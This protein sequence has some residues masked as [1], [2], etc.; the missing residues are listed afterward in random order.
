MHC[1]CLHSCCVTSSCIL[2]CPGQQL[3]VRIVNGNSPLEGRVEVYYNGTWGTVCD[4]YWSRRDAQ[5]VCRELGFLGALEAV[6][7]SRVPFVVL[8]RM[9]V[10]CTTNHKK[11]WG[12]TENLPNFIHLLIL[13][14]LLAHVPIYWP[15]CLS[16]GSCAALLAPVLLY[17][18]VCCFTGSCA[19]LLARVLLYWL[20]CCSTGLCAALL[21]R[22]LLYWLVCHSTGLCATVLSRV[23]TYVD[24]GAI[25]LCVRCCFGSHGLST[26]SCS[27]LQPQRARFGRGHGPIWMDDVACVGTEA[28]IFE[29]SALKWN[30]S[31]CYHGEDAG[32]ICTS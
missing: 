2:A 14:V 18:L 7:S 19:T 30:N 20:M 16:T 28:S 8:T 26:V 13:I 25:V 23:T 29:C 32:V 24:S 6:S 3:S 11:E 10:T 1:M 12:L 21:A 17:W 27:L 5:V 15:V 4:D 9:T 22:V 31:N